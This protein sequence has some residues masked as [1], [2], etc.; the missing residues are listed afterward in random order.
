LLALGQTVFWDEPLKAILPLLAEEAG[1]K[2]TLVAGVHDTDYFAKL[3]GGISTNQMFEALP[4]NDGSTR[5]FWSAA[6]EFSALFG[7]ET[8]V[9]RD[10]LQEA[11]VSI[12]RIGKGDGSALDAATEAWG[13]R[14]I[15]TADPVARVTSE[16]PI[17]RAFDEIQATFTWAIKLSRESLENSDD[18]T[19]TVVEELQTILCDARDGCPGQTLAEFYEC[20]LPR[21]HR[22][23]AGRSV[24]SEITRTGKLLRFD[25][26]HASLPRFS[27]V[28][29][30][31]KPETARIAKNAYDEA[32]RHT[33][34]YTLDRFGTGAIPF[35]LVIPGEGRGTVRLTSKMLI[36]MT[37][38]PKFVKL[39]KPIESIE[40]L[41]A[42]TESAFGRCVLVGKAITLIAM[43]AAEFVFAFHEGASTYVS[44][45]QAMLAKLSEAGVKV[46]ANPILRIA[47][48]ALDALRVT[49]RWFRLPDPLRSPFGA[50]VVSAATLA[51]SWRCVAEQQKTNLAKLSEARNVTKL[52]ECLHEIRGGRWQR[53]QEEYR[54]LREALSPLDDKLQELNSIITE[55]HNRLREIKA[56]WQNAEAMRGDAFRNGKFELREELGTQLAAMRSDRRTL[57]EKLRSLRKQKAD[58][59]SASDV[60][61][62]RER[63]KA[64]E[65][66]A[67]I[68]RLRTVREAVMATAGLEKSNRRP[69]AWWFPLVTPDGSWFDGL[70]SEVRLRLEPLI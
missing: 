25:R 41:S 12:D 5:D 26:E 68:A 57:L 64:I 56:L 51:S 39:D 54:S 24:A 2:V 59:A 21:L 15:A 13:W 70:R 20:M 49:D 4:K 6:G 60:R 36:V 61:A 38:E 62:A 34:V 30:F 58:E 46:H 10:T 42:V 19:E 45:T 55:T 63:R 66:E 69:A 31:L 44:Q 43:L 28:N 48:G 7:S 47:H 40:E 67:E 53:L 9:T 17:H 1:E 23:V 3:P 29:L 14:G 52:L 16:V 33:E 65:R 27:F 11:G 37:P 50:D 18:A 35:D 32:V 8:P 22:I